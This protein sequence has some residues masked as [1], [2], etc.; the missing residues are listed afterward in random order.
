M[1]I[2]VIF[3]YFNIFLMIHCAPISSFTKKS[4]RH[5]GIDDFN[6]DKLIAFMQTYGYLNNPIDMREGLVAESLYAEN[7]IIDGIKNVQRFGGLYP[8]GVMT[9]ETIKLLSAPR[10]GVKDVL[11]FSERKKRFVVG[12]KNWE[13]RKI[14]YFIANYSPKVNE[15]EMESAITKA[16]DAWSLY[17]RLIFKRINDTSA[18]II[19]AF[20]SYYHGDRYPFDGPGNILAHAFYPY[21]ENS[22][23]GDIHF[24][25]DENWKKGS[26]TLNDGVDFMTVAVH[27][28]G[29]SLGL[30][31]SPVYNAVM[32]PYYKGVSPAQLDYDDILGL[33]Q[34]YI[35][36]TLIDNT[37]ES[38]KTTT[39]EPDVDHKTHNSTEIETTTITSAATSTISTTTNHALAS[40]EASEEGLLDDEHHSPDEVPDFCEGD[41]DSMGII[42]NQLYIIKSNYVWKFDSKFKMFD[43]FPQKLRKIFPNLPRRFKK[44]DAFYE[45][46]ENNEIVMFSG[47]EYIT[48]DSRGPI[49]M[50][51]NLTRFTNDPDIE[52]IDAA[53]V[54]AKNKKTYLFTA[55]R[56]YRYSDYLK[57]DPFYPR[58]MKRWNG[59]PKNLK[60]PVNP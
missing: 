18:D 50:A 38:D 31:H 15:T 58:V 56:F 5:N 12:A 27:E 45:N 59:V 7:A 11:S 51:Y 6:A 34:L 36:R 20:G 60:V 37:D 4:L 23:G 55:N 24:D 39:P 43:N 52:K 2:F 1:K 44:I 29:H 41:Y 10:C 16:F 49:Y 28:L 26:Q 40:E 42:S 30:A 19:I 53:M 54:W 48:Y 13:K 22:Y 9:D 3:G 57:M 14:T 17:S 46:D 32:F 21:E 33:Y 35:Q 25:N 8:S 47:T